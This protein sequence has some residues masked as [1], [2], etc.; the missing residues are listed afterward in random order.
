[1]SALDPY[2]AKII[3]RCTRDGRIL[4]QH[5]AAQMGLA[6]PTV[7]QRYDPTWRQPETF[8]RQPMPTRAPQD[9]PRRK[10]RDEPCSPHPNDRHL[11]RDILLVMSDQ[12]LSP[13]QI[14]EKA[15]RSPKS[16][17]TRLTRLKHEGRVTSPKFGLWVLAV[18]E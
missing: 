15:E 6:E 7:R 17:R 5:V 9:R 1:M 10:L 11:T 12:P 2:E 16:V 14:A 18:Q 3:R 8:V 13:A 4:W